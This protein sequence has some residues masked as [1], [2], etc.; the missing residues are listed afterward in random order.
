MKVITKDEAN[1]LIPESGL[2]ALQPF[3]GGTAYRFSSKDDLRRLFFSCGKIVIEPKRKVPSGCQV[4]GYSRKLPLIYLDLT[5]ERAQ[6]IL[7]G[8]PADFVEEK[9]VSIP[10]P[11]VKRKIK[12]IPLPKV[13]KTPRK[14][15]PPSSFE[16]MKKRLMKALYEK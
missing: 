4:I 14:I 13:K 5:A 12:P 9:S 2:G 8:A 6:A 7:D 3:N 16:E 15:N 11:K 10:L 1:S